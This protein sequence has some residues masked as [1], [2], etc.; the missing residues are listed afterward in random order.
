VIN[1][2]Q[3]RGARGLIGVS[4]AALSDLAGV[5]VATI[6][7]LEAALEIRGSAASVA[8]VQMALEKS[9]VEFIP[10]DGT[11]GPGVRLKQAGKPKTKRG[12]RGAAA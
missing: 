8:K 11:K 1:A 9:G 2:A 5:S 10:G 4:Q 12:K 6:K 3:I 7:R